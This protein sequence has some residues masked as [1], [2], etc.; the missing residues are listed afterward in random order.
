[1]CPHCASTALSASDAVSARYFGGDAR[2]WKNLQA[3]YDLRN[4]EI[5]S[6]KRVEK[7]SVPAA[8]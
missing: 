4:A 2:S 7:E 3:A 1:M 8:A 5:E 6:A